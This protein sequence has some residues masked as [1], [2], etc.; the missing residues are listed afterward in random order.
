MINQV[1]VLDQNSSSQVK[2]FGGSICNNG[3]K[4]GS[5]PRAN[6]AQP[7]TSTS[8]F[9]FVEANPTNKPSNE[10]NGQI[11]SESIKQAMQ[12]SQVSVE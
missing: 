12:K 6:H 11:L 8:A 9:T 5:F 10:N 3:Q 1:A 7:Q 4:T 2:S